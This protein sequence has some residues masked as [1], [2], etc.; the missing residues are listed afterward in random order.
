MATLDSCIECRRTVSSSAAQCPHCGAKYPHGRTCDIC[1]RVGKDAE[2]KELGRYP[3]KWLHPKC[4]EE[5]MKEVLAVRYICPVC[6]NVDSCKIDT[7]DPS[8]LD[9]PKFTNPCPKCGHPVEEG[10][11]PVQCFFC[12]NYL[13]PSGTSFPRHHMHDVCLRSRPETREGIAKQYHNVGGSTPRTTVDKSGGCST[14]L[15][16]LL[17]LGSLIYYA[18]I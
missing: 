15:V 16:T 8:Q 14:V 7:R 1:N 3:V 17:I 4:Y 5:V 2:G 12:W 6:R 10:F 9:V 11:K 18:A 13:F